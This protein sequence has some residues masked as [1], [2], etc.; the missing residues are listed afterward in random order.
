[1]CVAV[2]CVQEVEGNAFPSSSKRDFLHLLAFFA[3]PPKAHSSNLCN[4]PSKH[5]CLDSVGGQ[6]LLSYIR[7]SAQVGL[8][9][10]S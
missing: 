9:T 6:E 2:Y 1:M 3:A 10:A 7:K 8:P 5:F 4:G